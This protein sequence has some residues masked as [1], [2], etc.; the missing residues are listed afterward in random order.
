MH[1]MN[2]SSR[3]IICMI[4]CLFIAVNTMYVEGSGEVYTE[5]TEFCSISDFEDF[6]YYLFCNTNIGTAQDVVN[7]FIGSDVET[8]NAG[9]E[10]YQK[11]MEPLRANVQEENLELEYI[12]L[13]CQ[14]AI[15]WEEVKGLTNIWRFFD[16]KE[17]K[18][19]REAGVCDN[20]SFRII[21]SGD[22][23][24]II[25]GEMLDEKEMLEK[26]GHTIVQ[27]GRKNIRYFVKDY[28]SAL[29]SL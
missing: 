12:S 22:A 1:K 4:C 16:G 5:E 18:E 25:D 23:Y 24:M 17:E 29:F 20:A 19:Q 26:E 2:K 27:K 10:L 6:H 14:F 28:E 13:D 11:F 21:K 3:K 7:A 15:T 8:S 9:I